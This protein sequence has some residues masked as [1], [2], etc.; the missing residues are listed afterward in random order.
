MLMVV[1]LHLSRNGISTEIPHYSE[2]MTQILVYKHY[3]TAEYLEKGFQQSMC[4]SRRKLETE[5]IQV[6]TVGYLVISGSIYGPNRC[7]WLLRQLRGIIVQ[8]RCVCLIPEMLMMEW[9]IILV[10]VIVIVMVQFNLNCCC[11]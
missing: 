11:C 7:E 5:L 6:I 4:S 8:V 1:T 10:A 9:I 2:G 3:T